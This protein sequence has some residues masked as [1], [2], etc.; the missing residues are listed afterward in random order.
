MKMKISEEKTTCGQMED[1]PEAVRTVHNAN[2]VYIRGPSSPDHHP[3]III[4]YQGGTCDIVNLT[5]RQLRNI[6]GDAVKIA[7]SLPPD[8]IWNNMW[9]QPFDWDYFDRSNMGG[10]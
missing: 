8:D 4:S 9:N 2:L 1:Q 6:A 3:Q 7:L 5:W 10:Q